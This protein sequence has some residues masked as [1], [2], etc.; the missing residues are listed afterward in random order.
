MTWTSDTRSDT[1]TDN[2]SRFVLM[3]RSSAS[4]KGGVDFSPFFREADAGARGIAFYFDDNLAPRLHE[5][6][7]STI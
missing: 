6:G 2:W 4:V 1:T 3:R 5:S 7:D